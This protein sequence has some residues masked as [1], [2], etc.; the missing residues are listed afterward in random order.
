MQRITHCLLRRVLASVLFVLLA[1][2]GSVAAS[3][4]AIYF[5]QCDEVCWINKIRLDGS[6]AGP[7][8]LVGGGTLA[9]DY[10]GRK[11]YYRHRR[12]DPGQGQELNSLR[13]A[14]LDGS[15]DETLIDY[16]TPHPIG[17][18]P[19]GRKVYWVEDRVFYRANLDGTDWE[20]L[21][22]TDF[23]VIDIAIDPWGG[24]FYWSQD[25]YPPG[26]PTTEVLIRRANLD[27][28]GTEPVITQSASGATTVGGMDVDGLRGSLYWTDMGGRAIQRSSLDGSEIV[29]LVL[30]SEV[31]G[32]VS[33]P[34]D[35]AVAGD[36]LV[37][38]WD[39]KIYGAD[40]SGSWI[41]LIHAP[42]ASGAL[43]LWTDLPPSAVVV[44]AISQ[45]G[46]VAAA[47]IV[48][49]ISTVIVRSHRRR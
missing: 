34:A 28:S 4:A 45:S 15:N 37:F 3:T 40:R 22:S 42:A 43:G 16:I 46:A 41:W 38:V 2:A 10:I 12:W 14:D 23:S 47:L 5:S 48:L 27:G 36:G 31:P 29:D 11:L 17:V 19:V 1:G 30:G 8:S 44:P 13:R 35:V 32:A 6:D 39:W 24:K 33:G 21:F 25:P 49:L 26:G 18:D 9:V 7:F 20:L